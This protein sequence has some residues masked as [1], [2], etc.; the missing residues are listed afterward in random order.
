MRVQRCSLADFMTADEVFM[1]GTTKRVTPVASI[2]G[3]PLR[4]GEGPGPLT[5]RLYSLLLEVEAA[6]V[7]P[8]QH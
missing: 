8:S 2:D 6:G 7:A 4:T 3:R 5:R 1:T